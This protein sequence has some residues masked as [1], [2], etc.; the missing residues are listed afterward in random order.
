[1]P[2]RY[3]WDTLR[4]SFV[5]GD[6]PLIEWSRERTGLDSSPKYKALRNRASQES[7]SERRRSYRQSQILELVN[8]SE[9]SPSEVATALGAIARHTRLSQS[10][11]GM[12]SSLSEKLLPAI[13]NLQDADFSML[14]PRQISELLKNLAQVAATAATIERQALGLPTVDTQVNV[15]FVVALP[16][17]SES[18]DEWAE[19]ARRSQQDDRN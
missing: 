8:P 2:A 15:G 3:E 6:S 19:M 4:Q 12:V 14:T 10:L 17:E 5:E 16:T 9:E 1:M 7:W 11:Q 13:A 18:I